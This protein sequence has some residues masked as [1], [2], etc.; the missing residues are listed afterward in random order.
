MGHPPPGHT[1]L[2]TLK[3][4]PDAPAPPRCCDS[5][6]GTGAHSARVVL[7]SFQSTVACCPVGDRVPR[8][9]CLLCACAAFV[10]ILFQSSPSLKQAEAL[11]C[12]VVSTWFTLCSVKYDGS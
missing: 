7:L 5:I 12:G 6:S 9:P 3:L 8:A 2:Y 11:C 4:P 10:P 1:E